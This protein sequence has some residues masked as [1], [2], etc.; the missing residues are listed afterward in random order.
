MC[1]GGGGEKGD[2]KQGRSLPKPNNDDEEELP[3]TMTTMSMMTTT[4]TKTT[5]TMT[6][7]KTMMTTTKTMTTTMNPNKKIVTQAHVKDGKE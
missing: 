1:N 4:M 3:L 2:S 6:I 5:T 7:T